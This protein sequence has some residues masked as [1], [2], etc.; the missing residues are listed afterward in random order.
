MSFFAV[1]FALLIEQLKPLP[2]DNWVHHTLV[3]WVGWTSRNFDAGRSHHTVVVWCVA[4]L[5]KT[6][7]R[8]S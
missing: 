8:R 5:G 4:V 6:H 2:R 3:S 1:L 7:R